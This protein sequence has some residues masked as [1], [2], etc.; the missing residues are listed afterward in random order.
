MIARVTI[1][2][3]AGVSI[4]AIAVGCGGGD[5]DTATSAPVLTKAK[6]I[7]QANEACEKAMAGVMKEVAEFE[8]RRDGQKASFAADAVHLVY[9]PAIESQIWRIEQIGAPVGE[10][11]EIDEMLYVEKRSLDAVAVMP[12]VPSVAAAEKHFTEADKL[13]RDYG[14]TSCGTG[15]E[16]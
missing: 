8:Q 1:L 13:L 15:S 12:R 16:S 2:L 4:A 10:L 9:L 3:A 11:E 6:F 14:L 5:S 7:E